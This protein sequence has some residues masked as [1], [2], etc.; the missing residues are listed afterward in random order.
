[1]RRNPTDLVRFSRAFPASCVF[2]R[3]YVDAGR[4]RIV[5]KL[6]ALSCAT[7]FILSIRRKSAFICVKRR[8]KGGTC[9]NHGEGEANGLSDEQRRRGPSALLVVLRV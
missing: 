8:G 3:A 9:Q 4:A 6:S 1:M 5:A 2:I 7:R